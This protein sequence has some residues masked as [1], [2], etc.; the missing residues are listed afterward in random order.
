MA[1]M[2]F[3]SKV[4]GRYAVVSSDTPYDQICQEI[5]GDDE[6]F[7][8][9]VHYV[10]GDPEGFNDYPEST[11]K[12]EAILAKLPPLRPGQHIE[13]S[14]YLYRGESKRRE[15]ENTRSVE[16]WTPN[17]DTALDFAKNVAASVVQRTSGPVQG[18][19]LSDLAY[20]GSQL[21]GKAIYA[22]DQAEWLV[23]RPKNVKTVYSEETGWVHGEEPPRRSRSFNR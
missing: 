20:W 18:V 23:L 2:R 22:G 11:K 14:R 1:N 19:A 9:V 15:F 10:S 5:V 16:S 8:H 21:R 7:E 6:L 12:L 13:F 17:K 4:S 3:L